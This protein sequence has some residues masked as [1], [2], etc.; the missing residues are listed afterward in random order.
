MSATLNESRTEAPP[1][2]RPVAGLGRRLLLADG[3]AMFGNW[4]DFL[5]ILTLAAY[6]Q[7]VSANFM[8]LLS[9]SL[10]LPGM[11]ASPWLGRCCDR[12]WAGPGLLASL[13]GRAALTLALIALIAQ[14]SW[15][16]LLAL[17]AGRSMLGAMT[18]PAVQ[19]L[20]VQLTSAQQRN[21][22]YARLSMVGSAAKVLA[23]LMGA[24][25]ASRLGEAAALWASV[26][27][28]LAA[29]AV[30][31]PVLSAVRQHRAD[32]SKRATPG[33]GGESA[34][35]PA[36]LSSLLP[37]LSLAA[38]FAAAV[39]MAGNLL[40]LVLQR[41]GLDKALLGSLV[42]S[43]GVGNLLAGLLISRSGLAARM[44][45][46]ERE[47]LVPMLA[48]MFCFGL[49]AAVLLAAPPAEWVWLLPAAFV[50][51]GLCSA[52]FAIMLNIYMSHQHGRAMGQAT[53]AM[54][55]AQQMMVLVAPLAGAWVLDRHGGA[56]VFA[57]AALLGTGWALL[58][59]S[60]G[61]IARRSSL[62][63]VALPPPP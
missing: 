5:A 4:I 27:C 61:L 7:Q 58:H 47:V 26:A 33:Q 22:Y 9:A 19:V 18:A 30:L 42:A 56:A 44:R 63:S 46:R 52:S 25:M 34:L 60:A 8:A 49:F 57:A 10:V 50:C 59:A 54:Q 24:G 15:A 36:C 20:A 35:S 31:W 11:L 1:L 3:L 23:P 16:W 12:G 45:G 37:L 14:P 39:F 62:L 55:A 51:S 29:A 43:G 13:L 6:Q 38:G 48:Q 40:P 32:A 28:A 2:D 17:A 53:A 41:Q 21:A